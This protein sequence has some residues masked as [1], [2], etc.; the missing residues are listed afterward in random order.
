MIEEFSTINGF[1]LENAEKLERVIFG[2]IGRTGSPEGGLGLEVAQK[3]PSLVLAYYDRLG[4]YITKGGVK[5]KTGSFWD[6]SR[7]VKAPHKEPK[8][9]FIF[10]IGGQSVEVDDPKN[11]ASAIME[12]EKVTKEKEKEVAK[13]KAKSKFKDTK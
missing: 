5:V 9:M 7:G 8:V 11:L 2:T 13:K 10:R 6:F 1:Q 3:D 4:G 12:V